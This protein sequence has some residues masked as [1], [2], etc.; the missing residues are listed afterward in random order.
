MSDQIDRDE[1]D[2]DDELRTKLRASDP[3]ASLAPADPAALARLLEDTM[4]SDLDTR[5]DTR[6]D[7]AAR[8]RRG[9]VTWLVGAAAAAVVA[10]GGVG[11]MARMAGHHDATPSATSHHKAAPKTPSTP[12][13][14]KLTAPGANVGKCAVPNA[15]NLATYTDTAF[16]GTVTAINGN[17]VT[18]QTT[19]AYA[20]QVGQTVEVTATPDDISALVSA[21]KFQVGGQYLVSA[22]G[23]QVAVCG[24]SGKAGGD[25]ASIYESAF[26]R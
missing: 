6:P 22:A 16:E 20:G 4:S 5:P 11:V 3:A 2:R 21:T 26:P 15:Q 9:R 23:G 8:S 17:T 19:R 24:F 12:A 7:A 1:F 18:L 13:I 14:T 10:A 25:L